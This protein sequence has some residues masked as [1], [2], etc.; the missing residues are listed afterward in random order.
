MS[1]FSFKL[2]SIEQFTALRPVL[3][4]CNI[5]EL[6]KAFE[7]LKHSIQAGKCLETECLLQ[8]EFAKLA[9]FLAENLSHRRYYMAKR[10]YEISL[11]VLKNIS[12]HA[13]RNFVSSSDHA[14]FYL[15]HK[16]Q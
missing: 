10:R 15:L 6:S 11:R 12:Q 1:Y 2:Y 4:I 3:I 9:F 8:D 14:M 13:K 5:F 16:Q 7:Y